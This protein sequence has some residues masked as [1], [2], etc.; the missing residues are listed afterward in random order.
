[1]LESRASA[2]ITGAAKL[3]TG[4]H[5]DGLVPLADRPRVYFAN[6][7][8]HID[9]AVVWSALPKSLRHRVHPVAANDYWNGSS[10]RR[11]F[12]EDVFHSV[13]V[14]R[15]CPCK[16]RNVL[17]PMLQILD[18]GESLILF[19]EGT[20][21]TGEEVLPFRSGVFNIGR[22]RP[23]V[24]FVPVW[25]EGAHRIM[26]KGAALP[27]P[28]FCRVNFGSPVRIEPEEDRTAFL[29]RMRGSLLQ[30]RKEHY[31]A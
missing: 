18:R 25:I 31:A 5:A 23:H 3:L 6:H 15:T 24:E 22:E 30:L 19:P 13:F 11:Y 26:P 16:S 1:M 27:L 21:G 4:C 9:F 12:A 8:S 14:E 20:R 7:T 2:I 10:W 29:N 28:L 17:T